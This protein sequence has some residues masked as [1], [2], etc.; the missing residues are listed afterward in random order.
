[1]TKNYPK[2]YEIWIANLDPSFGSE[3]GKIRPVI[4]LQSDLL[5]QSGHGS[6][7]ACVISS[8]HREGV[9]L[10][11][12][13]IDPTTTNGLMKKSFALCDQVRS[14]DHSRLM[15]RV[16][17]LDKETINRLTESIKVILGL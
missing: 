5:N 2:Q 6:F 3:P 15:G 4:I 14:I 9:S 11:R 10:I 12:L 1:M 13:A 7:I 8:Q 17:N 16:G